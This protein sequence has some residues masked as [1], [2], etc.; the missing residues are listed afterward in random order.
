MFRSGDLEK[1]LTVMVR[2]TLLFIIW[3]R[4]HYNKSSISMLSDIKY[5]M[6]HLQDY[7]QRKKDWLTLFT[8]KKIEV[9]HSELRSSITPWLD[10]AAINKIAK[11]I[12]A[13]RFQISF[14]QHFIHNKDKS[15]FEKDWSVVA[16]A[17]AKF[18][19][20]IFKKIASNIGKAFKVRFFI[21]ATQVLQYD[22]CFKILYY[23]M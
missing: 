1:H 18:L 23:T 4:R 11:C 6:G 10:A 16:G 19:L 3:K 12:N 7:F 8:E 2:I 5:Q 14:K 20:I 9:F 15:N 13:Q 17:S 21:L 22:E